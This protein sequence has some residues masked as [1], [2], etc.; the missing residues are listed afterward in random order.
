MFATVPKNLDADTYLEVEAPGVEPG[1]GSKYRN[2]YY[3]CS[4]WLISPC[5]AITDS[6]PAGQ[7]ILSFGRAPISVVQVLA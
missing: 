7:P 5:G 4:R 6:L 3:A 1:S 2:R